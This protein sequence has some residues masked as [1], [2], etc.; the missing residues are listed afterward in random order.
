M[1]VD[2]HTWSQQ[3]RVAKHAFTSRAVALCEHDRSAYAANQQIWSAFWEALKPIVIDTLHDSRG[4][5]ARN[6]LG[7]VPVLVYWIA[8]EIERARNVGMSTPSVHKDFD[9]LAEQQKILDRR[10]ASYITARCRRTATTPT[11][12]ATLNSW[13]TIGNQTSARSP[14]RRDAGPRDAPISTES[15]VLAGS[16]MSA[17]HCV[18]DA[19]IELLATMHNV[20]AYEFSAFTNGE[21]AQCSDRGGDDRSRRSDSYQSSTE[22]DPRMPTPI[23]VD[24]ES[25]RAHS[26]LDADAIRYWMSAVHANDSR[27]SSWI[28]QTVGRRAWLIHVERLHSDEQ[29]QI[30]ADL[31][32]ASPESFTARCAALGAN[33]LQQAAHW[34]RA[35]LTT[36]VRIA[37]AIEQRRMLVYESI[38]ATDHVTGGIAPSIASTFQTHAVQP[39]LAP[40]SSQVSPLTYASTG[41]SDSKSRTAL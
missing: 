7:N 14:E 38:A 41:T 35:E 40:S 32:I 31:E 30:L 18:A 39:G 20:R 21:T 8:T 3:I 10:V 33:K 13:L 25:T 17:E 16:A 2:I 23:V 6:R 11:N 9:N 12:T 4:F 22:V 29:S 1:W 27:A 26:P 28:E 5:T 37:D 34:R 24:R 19:A 36:Y 15:A